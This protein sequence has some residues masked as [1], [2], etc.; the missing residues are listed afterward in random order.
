MEFFSSWIRGDFLLQDKIYNLFCRSIW[1]NCCL[2]YMHVLIRD[3]K[4]Y[5]SRGEHTP[6]SFAFYGLLQYEILVLQQKEQ[7]VSSWWSWFVRTNSRQSEPCYCF[8]PWYSS[9]A[10]TCSLGISRRE[11]PV[12]ESATPL[13]LDWWL[14][15]DDSCHCIKSTSQGCLSTANRHAGLAE[16]TLSPG[17]RQALVFQCSQLEWHA[18]THLIGQVA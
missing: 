7:D 10:M 11:V 12:G 9:E 8:N 4:L 15:A 2:P 6:L 18:E 14:K 5:T 16:C 13:W 17:A 1:Q 3:N